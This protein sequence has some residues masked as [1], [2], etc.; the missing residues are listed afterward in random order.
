MISF[1]T[2]TLTQLQSGAIVAK[3]LFHV[4]EH[5][6]AHLCMWDGEQD[7]TFT[8]AGVSR[9]FT[10]AGTL[11]GSDPMISKTGLSVR[12]HNIY[13]SAVSQEVEDLV[14][15]YETRFA[16]IRI[17]RVLLNPGTRTP[18]AN[19]HR[20]FKGFVNLITFERPAPGAVGTCT[21][22]CASATRALTRTLTLKQSHKAQKLRSNDQFRKYADISGSIPVVWGQERHK[23]KS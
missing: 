7:E 16:P 2:A 13:L 3:I 19:P 5:G 6:G 8:V 12:M 14:K 18:V 11:I 21:V 23:V 1:D 4:E 17:Y 15:G 10:G 20:V 22:E 9:L